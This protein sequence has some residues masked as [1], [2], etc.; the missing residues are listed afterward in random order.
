MRIRDFRH[1]FNGK[2]LNHNPEG[3]CS[4]LVSKSKSY[5]DLGPC[6]GMSD[7]FCASYLTW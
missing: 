6:V 2:D 3:N 7:I 5:S 1:S 4:F